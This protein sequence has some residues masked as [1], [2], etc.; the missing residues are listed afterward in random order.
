MSSNSNKRIAKN[1]LI[2]YVR[3]FFIMCVS[4][5]TSRIVI[6]ALGIDDYGVYTVIGGFVAMFGIISNSL[7]AAIIRFIT[8]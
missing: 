6:N 7:T 1:T 8:Y 2:L 3:M 4:L 5:Y